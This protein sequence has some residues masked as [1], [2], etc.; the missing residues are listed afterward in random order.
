MTVDE[1]DA[2]NR[3][4]RAAFL[5]AREDG[6]PIEGRVPYYG[7]VDVTLPDCPP[8]V[9]FTNNDAPVVDYILIDGVFE[10]TSMRLWRRL[11]ETATGVMDIGANIGIYSLVAALARQD[12][13]I[14][15]FE[16]NPYAFA[17]LRMHK[18]INRAANIR[19]HT[20]A[21]GDSNRAMPFAWVIKPGGNIASGAGIQAHARP[22][23]ERI[24]VPMI[25]LD[26]TGF[27]RILG[28]APLIKIDIEGAEWLAF[29]GM[30]EV[31]AA[32]PDIILETFS[33]EACAAI[34]ARVQPL[35]YAAYLIR[36]KEG[37]LVA[38]DRLL[39]CDPHDA[40]HDFNQFL[41]VRPPPEL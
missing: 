2:I 22:D 15:A 7:Y 35:G 40:D 31:L 5:K 25:K 37:R 17:R 28:P 1:I 36:E 21:V 23:M 30:S 33:A 38:R 4:A 39:P 24:T 32:K 29:H 19:E 12:L 14:H 13:D 18:E 8:F 34:T 6:R 10:P 26:G 20:C 16:P 11:C 9:L 41:T 27:D 3:A